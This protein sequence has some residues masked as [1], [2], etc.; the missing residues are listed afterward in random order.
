MQHVTQTII[1]SALEADASVAPA[2]R[3]QLLAMLNGRADRVL[4]PAEVAT[5]FGV[6]KRSIALW[7]R[8]GIIQRIML[9]GRKRGCGYRESDVA[10]LIAGGAC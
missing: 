6:S 5:R 1:V 7:S 2:I 3:Q 9:P 4:K 10:R 8:K